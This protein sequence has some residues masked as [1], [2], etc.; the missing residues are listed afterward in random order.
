MDHCH[1]SGTTRGYLCRGCNNI[2]SRTVHPAFAAWRAG[3]NPARLLGLEERYVPLFGGDGLALN[4]Q[5][6]A[7]RLLALAIESADFFTEIDGLPPKDHR[8]TYEIPTVPPS[9]NAAKLAEAVGT[10]RLDESA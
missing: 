3:R 8:I 5:L 6:E 4:L 1:L 9:V 2:E 10:L 7:H